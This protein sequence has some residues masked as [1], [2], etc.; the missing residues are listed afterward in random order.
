MNKFFSS[1]RRTWP[2]KIMIVSFLFGAPPLLAGADTLPEAVHRGNTVRIRSLL[3]SRPDLNLPDGDGNTALHWAARHGDAR[4]VKEL[5]E[6]GASATA[7]NHVG[8][9]PIL[10]AVGNLD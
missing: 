8:A 5:L 4:L 6:R 7:T 9:T 10:Y 2:W 3:A 1:P